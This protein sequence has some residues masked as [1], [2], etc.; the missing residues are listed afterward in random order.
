MTETYL[1]NNSGQGAKHEFELHA[2]GCP[3]IAKKLAGGWAHGWDVPVPAGADLAREA[4]LDLNADF[5]SDYGQTPEE[6]V[7]A[8]EGYSVHVL[9][10]AKAA[11]KADDAFVVA[12][13]AVYDASTDEVTG[14]WADGTPEAAQAELDRRKA[15][16]AGDARTEAASDWA[17]KASTKVLKGLVK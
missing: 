12:A 7:D 11:H 14:T 3:D 5:A 15:N 17:F 4:A 8:G 1:I 10:C 6:Y 16:K 9:P 13:E 2:K